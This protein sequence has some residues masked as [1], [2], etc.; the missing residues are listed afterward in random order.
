MKKV[1]LSAV[2]ALGVVY[3]QEK[4]PENKSASE[5]S[6]KEFTLISPGEGRYQYMFNTAF[7]EENN[8]IFK[9]SPKV[10]NTVLLIKTDDKILDKITVKN[11]DHFSLSLAKYS[12]YSSL[13]WVLTVNESE[14]VMK[15]I[16]DIR[17][18]TPPLFMY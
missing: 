2:L 15:G 14:E 18:Y 6:K 4:V 5:A 1:V 13:A 8:V 7:P 12:S 9:W 10:A 3:A 11:T 17:K 16:I